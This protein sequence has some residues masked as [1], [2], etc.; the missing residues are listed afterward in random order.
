LGVV[1]WNFCLTSLKVIYINDLNFASIWLCL[2]NIF[3]F[4]FEKEL[5]KNDNK[6]LEHAVLSGFISQ[7]KEHEAIDIK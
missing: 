7:N 5:L 4:L 1:E 3:F 6:V 2:K